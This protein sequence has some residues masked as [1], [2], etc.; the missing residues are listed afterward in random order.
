M[1]KNR[2][3]V[4]MSSSRQRSQV[5]CKRKMN[6]SRL[7]GRAVRRAGSC[8]KKIERCLRNI[9]IRNKKYSIKSI[10]RNPAGLYREGL[11]YLINYQ[12]KQS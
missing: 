5:V 1:K 2:K 10:K 12:T 4:T 9:R 6:S 8:P 11:D 7:K 3:E